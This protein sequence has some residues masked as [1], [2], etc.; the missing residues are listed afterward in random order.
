M[1]FFMPTAKIHRA[2]PVLILAP[3]SRWTPRAAYAGNNGLHLIHQQI[4]RQ[5]I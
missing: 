3:L 5:T 1:K 2:N 4:T